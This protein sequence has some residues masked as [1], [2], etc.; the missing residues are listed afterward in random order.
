MSQFHPFVLPFIF[1]VISLTVACIVKW[2]RW[3]RHFTPRQ[4]A[5]IRR[6]LISFKVFR[7]VDE[8][9]NECLFHHRVFKRNL[10]LGYMHS[11]IALGWFLLIVVGAVEATFTVNGIRWPW[12]AIFLRYFEHGVTVYPFFAQIM[13]TLLLYVLSGVTLAFWK[14]VWHRVVG[15]KKVTR[16]T[17]FDL[18]AKYSLW[19]IFPLRL[20]SES[21]SASL[22]NNG[23]W[24]TQGIGELFTTETASV[25]EIPFWTLYSISLGIFFVSM[26]FSRYMHIFTEVPVIFFRRLGVR[27]ETNRSGFTMYELSAC[28]RCGICIDSCPLNSE[29]GHNDVQPVYFLRDIRYK[30]P[31]LNV[32]EDCLLCGRCQ[33]ECPVGIDLLSI[34]RQM[35]DRNGIDSS[36]SYDY[37]KDVK[38]FNAIGR[39]GY[40][41]GCMGHLTPSVTESMKRIFEAAGQK[42]WHI[43]ENGTMCCGRPLYQQG[44]F[45]QAEELRAQNTRFILDSGIKVL[46][47][48]CPICYQSFTKEYRLKGITVLHHS[49]YMAALIASGNIILSPNKGT[50]TYHDPCE[51]GRGCGIY[52][53]PRR[54]VEAVGELLSV[55]SE[56]EKSLCCGHNL[57]DTVLSF[58]EQARIR[59]AAIGNLMSA[60]PGAIATACP[61]CK[62]ALACGSPVPVRDI[63]ELV[64]ESIEFAANGSQQADR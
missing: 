13:D 22:W 11:S 17:A 41:S 49:Q 35:R 55:P 38:P 43:D 50:F 46:V 15:M 18:F 24:L 63:A 62:K 53:E 5:N 52:D 2:V 30:R 37:L 19:F 54:V 25:L 57:G 48:S 9:V 10:V 39:I 3:Y 20:M 59:D 7:A 12:T 32:A 16:H 29:L 26:P 34:R 6:N 14:S 58:E 47:T 45:K 8:S 64:A 42:Y 51:L 21:I 60:R 31:Q 23:G 27:E 4:R 44:F 61:M 33:V 56:R 36:G 40:F 28:S 1:G